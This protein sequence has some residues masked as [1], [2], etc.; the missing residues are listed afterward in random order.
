[1]DPLVNRF[2]YGT[3]PLQFYARRVVLAHEVWDN[4]EKKLEVQGEGYQ[5][6]RRSFD[7][8]FG[9]AG[10]A[11]YLSSKYIGGVYRGNVGDPGKRLPFEPVPAAQQKA[12][13]DILRK[14]LFS[15]AS[16]QFSPDLLNKLA[17][18]RF[19]DWTDID[20]MRTRFDVPIHEMVF[21]LQNRVLDRLY[22]P[23]VLNRLLDSEVK[24]SSPSD[25]LTVGL[26]FNEIQDSV[27]AELKAPG[28]SIEI[29]TYRR[30]LQRAHLRKL[31]AIALRTD[32]VPEDA[33]TMA[34]ENLTALRI[35]IRG[36][37]SK[38]GLK[39]SL[40]TRAHL[41]E[42]L[43]RIDD[44]LKAN[45]QTQRLLSFV[46]RLS[47]SRKQVRKRLMRNAF[48]DTHAVI[49]VS[50]VDRT[51]SANGKIMTPV[52]L[53]VVIAVAAP[54]RENFAGEIELEQLTTIRGHRFEVAS[55]DHIK[56]IVGADC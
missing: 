34:R 28:Q 53:A 16:F 40:E 36:V 3:D 37:V 33:Q 22:D 2:D 52:D 7:V 50:D 24:V 26:L 38:P 19:S 42:S 15:P 39:T 20:S 54:F 46:L 1:M 43:A 8:A 5:V 14:E 6:L 9:Q 10:C 49:D 32:S 17:S 4:M 35:Q 31:V 23:V 13:L 25:A 18:P 41:N 55:I 27:W 21:G 51:I 11:L 44:T 30:S 56:Q 47:G 29:N 45:M 48:L 12:A